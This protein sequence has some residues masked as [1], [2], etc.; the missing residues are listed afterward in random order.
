[1][2]VLLVVTVS[3]AAILFSVSLPEGVSVE[4]IGIAGG[5]LVMDKPD[6]NGFDKNNRPF[7][8]RAATATQDLKNPAIIQLKEIDARLPLSE[9]TFA[10]VD[11]LTGIYDRDNERLQLNKDIRVKN[12]DGL[13]IL[14]EKADIDMKSGTLVSDR[15]VSV[16]SGRTQV[17]SDRLEVQD[18]GKLIIFEHRV[19]MVIEPAN[20][21]PDTKGSTSDG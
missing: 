10:D 2:A 5:K 6:L 8:V 20:D 11:A 1:M 7:E 18:N 3:A 13:E 17:R 16:K 14:L 15:P 4:R 19:R 21:K 9:S 12:S